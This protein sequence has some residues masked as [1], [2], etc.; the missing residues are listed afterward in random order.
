MVFWYQSCQGKHNTVKHWVEQHLPYIDK[1]QSK[2]SLSSGCHS[3]MANGSLLA[4]SRGQFAPLV[5]QWKETYPSSWRTDIT[6]GLARCHVTHILG[7]D[8]TTHCT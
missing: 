7:T 4:A 3:F 8:K 1:R 2:I 6:V 5:L